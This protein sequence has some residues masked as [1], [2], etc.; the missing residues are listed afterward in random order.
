MSPRSG[1]RFAGRRLSPLRLLI[2][3]A[4]LVIIPA[5]VAAVTVL[6]A[7]PPAVQ[8]ASVASRW[9]AGYYDVTLETGA[10]LATSAF[11]SSAGGA[12]LAFVVAAGDQDCTPTWGKNYTL[13]QAGQTFQLDRRIER[14]RREGQPLA[15]SFGGAIN[16]ELAAACS[17]TSALTAA[18][19]SV[20][21][22]YQIDVMDLDLEGDMLTNA[23][24]ST[25]R[26]QAV[27][28]LQDERRSSG[29]SLDV[30]LTLPVSPQGLTADGI[31][32][33]DA[34]LD[35]GV[36]IAGVNAMTMDFGTDGTSPMSSLSTDALTA[37]EAQLTTVWND[38]KRA[39]PAGGAWALLGATPM[40]GRND[41][42]REIFSTDDA[43]ALNAFATEHGVQRLSMWSLN[44]DQTCGSNY[45]N[46]T[47]VS[48]SCSGIEQAGE[49]FATI[50]ADGYGGTPSGRPA[51]L[52][53]SEIV[54][55]DA[56]TSPYPIWSSATYYSAGVMVVWK[57]SVYVSKW[58]NEDGATPDD[59]TLDAG[60]SAWSY[61]GPVLAS[62]TPFALPTL[63]PG[64][65]PDWSATTLYDQGDRVQLNG[66]AYEARWWSQGKSPDRSVLDHDYSPWKLITGP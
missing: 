56:T 39:L 36:D 8:G 32:Q 16:T 13:D 4:A 14:M 55:D 53:T 64:T 42:P 2:S 21:D 3:L 15:V 33:V 7:L 38:R 24:A 10:Q 54:P 57:G 45:P 63:P 40:I 49:S 28:Q 11:D 1:S 62:D 19:R 65:Y 9:F 66:T 37:T 29:G 48:T 18:Y 47:I 23:P 59:P 51:V 35:A 43:R 27:A 5:S 17:S 61:L 60:A 6:P 41:V 25:R 46:L 52:E 58:W 30:W 31:A 22:R 50:L 44:R 20:M 34:L 12:V 26:A